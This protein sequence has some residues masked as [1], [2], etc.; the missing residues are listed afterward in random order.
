MKNLKFHVSEL[1]N[2]F[3]DAGLNSKLNTIITLIGEEMES[4]NELGN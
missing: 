3:V 1:K 4:N 2:S